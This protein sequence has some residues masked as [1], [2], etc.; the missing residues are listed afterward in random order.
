[1]NKKELSSLRSAARI[2]RAAQALLEAK[3]GEDLYEV[4]RSAACAAGEVEEFLE[5]YGD[6]RIRFDK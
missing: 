6:G 2:L 3:Y 4:C 5:D 1:M